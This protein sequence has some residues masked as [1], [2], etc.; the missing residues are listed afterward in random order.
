MTTPKVGDC[1]REV[2]ENVPVAMRFIRREMRREGAAGLSV[3]QFRALLMLNQQ[4]GASLSEVATHLG[5]TRPTASTIIERLVQQKLITREVDPTERRRVVLTLTA[6]GARRLERSRAHTH[7]RV[8]QVL[9]QLSAA[10]QAQIAAALPLLGRVFR[11]AGD[12]DGR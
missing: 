11:E 9:S 10:E 5:V 7:E 2:M 6:E 12:A 4:P 8:T 1:A 3:P